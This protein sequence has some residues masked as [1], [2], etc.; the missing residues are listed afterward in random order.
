MKLLTPKQRSALTRLYREA[1]TRLAPG[2]D[3]SFDEFRRD[4]ALQICG[5]RIS[6][7]PAKAFN[8][9][10]AHG[11]ALAGKPNKAF[12]IHTGPANDVRQLLHHIS[13][14]QRRQGLAD[15]YTAGICRRMFGKDTP[16]TR[17]EAVAVLSA[18]KKH[19]TRAAT[20]E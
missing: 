12:D 4:Q 6:E 1:F 10:W 13:V 14:E 3:Q 2:L 15:A 9:L 16:A 17:P 20:K 5:A 11:L 18:L 8:A 19:R 7:A